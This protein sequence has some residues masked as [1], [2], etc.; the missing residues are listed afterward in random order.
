MQA[1][2]TCRTGPYKQFWTQGVT[3]GIGASTLVAH[4]Y[5]EVYQGVILDICHIYV[6]SCRGR[7]P[8]RGVIV[9]PQPMSSL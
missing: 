7:Q 9:T 1:R 3:D 4:A 5:E 8:L 6:V 2:S